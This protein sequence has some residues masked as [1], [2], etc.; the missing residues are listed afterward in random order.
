MIMS[1]SQYY[2][3]EQEKANEKLQCY[4]ECG[5]GWLPLVDRVLKGLSR[6]AY[7]KQVKEKFGRLRIYGVNFTPDDYALIHEAE[8]HSAHVCEK[9]GDSGELRNTRGYLLVACDRCFRPSCPEET[10]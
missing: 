6:R 4:V 7:L 9:C 10:L 8:A 1:A 2:A 5:D 3:E